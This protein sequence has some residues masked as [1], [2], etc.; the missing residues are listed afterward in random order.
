MGQYEGLPL[1]TCGTAN[2]RILHEQAHA[3][4][5]HH[6]REQLWCDRVRQRIQLTVHQYAYETIKC[7]VPPLLFCS[8]S[9][10]CGL[11]AQSPLSDSMTRVSDEF[12]RCLPKMHQYQALKII[13]MASL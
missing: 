9:A 3:P 5:P 7:F 11:I 13:N 10:S 8:S 6:R 2:L 1:M 12:K 4:S